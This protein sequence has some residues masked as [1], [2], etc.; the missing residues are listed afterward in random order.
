[1]AKILCTG[2]ATVDIINELE[3]YPQEDDEVRILSQSITRGGNATNTAVVLSR[4]GHQCFWAGT[5]IT[6]PSKEHAGDKDSQIII[7]DLEQ[8]QVNTQYVQF[9]SR[10]KVPTSYITLSRATGSRTICHY[11]DLAEYPFEAFKQLPL[12]DFDWFHFE[13]RNIEHTLKMMKLCRKRLPKVC[14]SLEIEKVRDNIETLIPYADMVLFSK[15]YAQNSKT[16]HARS[17]CLEK[18]R[19]YPQALIVCAW[20]KAG[21]GAAF[22]QVFYW[23]DGFRVDTVDS[24]GAGDVFNAAM[25]HQQLKQQSIIQ[26]LQYACR[27]AAEKCTKKGLIT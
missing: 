20:G 16:P 1:M 19:Q 27:K 21:A 5:C 18:N 26:S 3:S 12:E 25:I 24:L 9:L 10:G 7:D 22:K 23:Q 17:F 11:R 14:I 15:Q 8:H 6:C 4:L 13:G 2:I